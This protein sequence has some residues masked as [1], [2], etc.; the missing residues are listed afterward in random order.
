MV[1]CN[2]KKCIYQKDNICSLETIYYSNKLCQSYCT[3]NELK[4]LSHANAPKIKRDH[5][6][7]KQTDKR[8]FK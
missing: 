1:Y 8:I 7:Y 5:S 4:K 3:R 6:R 2:S